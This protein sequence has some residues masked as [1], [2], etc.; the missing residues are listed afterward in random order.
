VRPAPSHTTN[1]TGPWLR[2]TP[3]PSPVVPSALT[4]YQA[5][6]WSSIAQSTPASR[7]HHNLGGG[8]EIGAQP[9]PFTLTQ[10]DRGGYAQ[11]RR[12]A[13]M[14]P[15]KC[16]QVWRPAVRT[17]SLLEERVFELQVPFA[18][19]DA[20]KACKQSSLS[21]RETRLL[22]GSD[23]RFEEPPIFKAVIP[24]GPPTLIYGFGTLAKQGITS[25][26]S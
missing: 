20:G 4:R 3:R 11:D 13:M 24:P 23:R 18:L 9:Q 10:Q 26:L 7:A 15:D 14:S 12:L 5:P 22:V 25:K 21:R 2:P 1:R 17:A 8:A 16:L 19:P 6:R